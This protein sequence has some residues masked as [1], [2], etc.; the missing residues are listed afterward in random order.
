MGKGVGVNI[1]VTQKQEKR[2]RICKG[3]AIQRFR[4]PTAIAPPSG[5]SPVLPATRFVDVLSLVPFGRTAWT[6]KLLHT[7]HGERP[8]APP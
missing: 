7:L 2:Q 5:Q 4:H 6:L 1:A 3:P 8:G